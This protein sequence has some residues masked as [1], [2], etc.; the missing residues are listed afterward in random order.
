MAEGLKVERLLA[1]LSEQDADRFMGFIGV[2]LLED[3]NILVI[4]DGERPI[5]AMACYELQPVVFRASCW[6]LSSDERAEE[7]FEALLSEFEK[8][9]EERGAWRREIFVAMG[10]AVFACPLAEHGYSMQGN[11]EEVIFHRWSPR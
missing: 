1:P 2:D 11:R 7:Q 10:C 6:V 8:M 3:E 9:A 5:A 4:R